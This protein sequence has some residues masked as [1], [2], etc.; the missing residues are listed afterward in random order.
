MLDDRQ[1]VKNLKR[2]DVDALRSIY[3]KYGD[4]L[5]TLATFLSLDKEAA[6]D[7][8]HDVF[9]S[10]IEH[11][12]TFELSGSLKA[13]LARCVANRIIDI[14]RAKSQKNISLD[15][16]KPASSDLPGPDQIATDDEQNLRINTALGK[17]PFEQREVILLHLHG[18]MKFNQIS[19]L[20]GISINTI[21]G[22]YRYGIEKLRSIFKD[23]VKN[24]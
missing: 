9:V 21:Q 23:E 2:G 10:F 5:L 11:I 22:R 1:L 14:S 13:F 19:R 15:S 18:G 12:E 6:E 8:L 16:S 7:I 20:R 3:Q 24:A 17:L 4:G